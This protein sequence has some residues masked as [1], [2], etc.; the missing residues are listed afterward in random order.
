MFFDHFN[1]KN[2]IRNVYF[3]RKLMFYG[4]LGCENGFG[5]V[6]VLDGCVGIGFGSGLKQVENVIFGRVKMKK[7]YKVCVI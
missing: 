1:T 3:D 7:P 4:G 2:L 6:T 5:S